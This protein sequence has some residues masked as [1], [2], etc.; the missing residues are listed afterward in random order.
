MDVRRAVFMLAAGL[1]S[2]T[3][4]VAPALS[5][6]PAAPQVFTS[7]GVVLDTV[8]ARISLVTEAREDIAVTI[9]PGA[10]GAPVPEID[11]HRGDVRVRGARGYRLRACEID[12]ET[13]S[14]RLSGRDPMTLD[15]LALVEITAPVGV[16]LTVENGRIF[17]ALGDLGAATLVLSQCAKLDIARVEEALTLVVNGVG[18]VSVGAVA[19]ADLT[20]NGAGAVDVA[21]VTGALSA[22]VAGNGDINVDQLDGPARLFI[23]GNGDITV[24]GG[25]GAGFE[26]QIAGSGDIR[27]GGVAVDPEVTISGS[28]DV[29]IAVISG[30]LRSR[31][32][33]SGA[34]R[35]G[36]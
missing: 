22:E 8:L 26:A 33:G 13:A 30:D 3:A 15:D 24:T 29:R 23:A 25:R 4:S 31:V 10:V 9:T 14:L 34:V 5:Q 35:I 19:Q 21:T 32:Y 27:F 6:S 11:V 1:A 2:W 28:G 16:D 36:E 7:D 20:V 12:G 17:G 18:D